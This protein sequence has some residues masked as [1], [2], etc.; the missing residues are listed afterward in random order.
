MSNNCDYC[1][2]GTKI[3]RQS[4]HKKGVAG[5]QWAK[6]AQSTARTFKP[7]LQLARID[8]IQFRLCTRCL[9]RF[10][11]NQVMEKTAASKE[12]ISPAAT[13]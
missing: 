11:A 3:G 5:R 1:E 10:K 8:G 7:N 4:R 6:R 12:N 13:T 9:K 2:K